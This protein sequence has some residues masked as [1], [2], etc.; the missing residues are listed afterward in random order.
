MAVRLT[1]V[2]E[3][4]I[5]FPLDD[6][7][8]TVGSVVFSVM[9]RLA[10]LVQPLAP[11][12][13]AVYVPIVEIDSAALDPTFVAPFDQLYDKP[14]VALRLMEVVLQVNIVV[15][16]RLVMAAVGGVVFCVIIVFAVAVQPFVPV[17]VTVYVPGEEI[18][19]LE[20]VPTTLVPLL[21]E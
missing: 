20:F 7:I 16:V 19:K 18:V 8:V 13:V 15:P 14:P 11:V 12:T 1:E 10:V 6:E 4:L 2:M 3:Q 5:I 9:V 21:H 17:T